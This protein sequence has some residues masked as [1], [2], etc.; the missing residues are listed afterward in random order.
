MYAIPVKGLSSSGTGASLAIND[1]S[2]ASHDWD[3]TF[4]PL[5]DNLEVAQ[6]RE[7]W[8]AE[9]PKI[10]GIVFARDLMEAEAI[11]LKR[12][13][14]TLDIINFA[15]SK[16]HQP[17]RDP[18]RGDPFG[19]GRPSCTRRFPLPLHNNQGSPIRERLGKRITRNTGHVAR[20]PT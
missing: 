20:G 9:T 7:Y 4:Q 14:T 10:F 18:L 8:Q 15:C 11:S 12:A 3:Q 6:D 19:L 17:F 16:R 13:N 1:S 5:L 2:I